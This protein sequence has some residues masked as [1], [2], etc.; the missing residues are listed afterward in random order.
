[1]L[2]AA[3]AC[4]IVGGCSYFSSDT[5]PLDATQFYRQPDGTGALP[6]GPRPIPER[7]PD[8]NPANESL[9]SPGIALGPANPAPA[10]AQAP[11]EDL[12]F[13]TNQVH[14]ALPATEPNAAGQADVAPPAQRATAFAPGQFMPIG[15]V[16]A[17]V[18]GNPIYADT[19]LRTVAP[20]LAARAKDLDQ[21]RFRELASSEIQRQVEESIRAEVE[22]AAADRNTT[23]EEKQTADK[24]TQQ[25]RDKLVTDNKGSVEAVRRSYRDQGTSYDDA[26]KEQYRLNL[27][28][29]YYAK[30]LFPRIQ[31]TADDMRRFYE[32]NKD[33][34]FTEHDAVTFRIIKITPAAMG[35][36]DAAKKKI[37]E[38]AARAGR[39]ED[40]AQIAGEI[41]NDP[42]YL[43]NHGLVGPVDRGAFRIDAIDK[44]LWNIDVGQVT[45]VIPAEGAYFIAR[46]EAKKTGRVA[47]FEED[48][49]QKRMLETLRSQQFTKLRNDLESQLRRD[50]V[51]ARNDQMGATTVD[52]AMQNFPRWHQ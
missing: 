49:V 45:P 42:V 36:D 23:A 4:E 9:T 10:A 11:V 26:A 5:K 8:A 16:I 37:T 40:F 3:V 50:S 28:R 35:T 52:M 46:L 44:A 15:G 41:N 20:V 33:T 51:V 12:K 47:A 17:E 31:V 18:N 43:K 34:A 13:V 38:L 27:V 24:L 48:A 32:K 25:W 30:K 22:Y 2:I 14:A 39:G 19:V 1:M 6:P 21:S 29:V 7:N